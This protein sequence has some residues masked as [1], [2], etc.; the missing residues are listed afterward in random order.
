MTPA[1]PGH[2]ANTS[3]PLASAPSPLPHT[4]EFWV[5]ALDHRLAL[6]SSTWPINKIFDKMIFFYFYFFY[7]NILMLINRL[8]YV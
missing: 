7:L 5:V 3:L 8:D 1:G 6:E 2:Q 4:V